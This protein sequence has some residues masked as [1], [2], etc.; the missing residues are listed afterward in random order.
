MQI[1]MNVA[2][3]CMITAFIQSADAREARGATSFAISFPAARRDKALDG[4]VIL[5]LSRD[6]AREP[7][8]HV[9]PN[10]PLACP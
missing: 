2:A 9:E 3:V 4:R 10:E 5:L 7:R 1:A 8:S 6:L